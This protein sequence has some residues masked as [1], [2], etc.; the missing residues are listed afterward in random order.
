[1]NEPDIIKSAEAADILGVSRS[2]F[3][4]RVADG[5][6]IPAVNC[7]GL[8]GPRLFDR[9]VIEQLAAKKAQVA[10]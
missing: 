7:P 1:M 3:N 9:K 8:T 5:D 2:T 10:A 6:I 4:R